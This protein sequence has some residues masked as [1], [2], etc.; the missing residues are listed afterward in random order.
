MDSAIDFSRIELL[1]KVCESFGGNK[2]ES[3]EAVNS[4]KYLA[5]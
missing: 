2:W 3:I 1:V 4:V 5:S